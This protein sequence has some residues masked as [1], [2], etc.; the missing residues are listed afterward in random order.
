M[1]YYRV[2]LFS[3]DGHVAFGGAVE[4]ASYEDARQLLETTIGAFPVAEIWDHAGRVARFAAHI[5]LPGGQWCSY[6]EMQEKH[7]QRTSA[8]D[9][10]WEQR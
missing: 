5:G 1:P 9:Q 3:I 10:P 7:Q 6:D 4:N 8:A 2:Y